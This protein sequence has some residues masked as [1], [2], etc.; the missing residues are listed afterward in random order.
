MA[1][2]QRLLADAGWISLAP[3]LSLGVSG[4]HGMYDCTVPH[5][6]RRTDALAE[7]GRWIDWL[8]EQGAA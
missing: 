5:V 2:L 3:M 4:R 6:P 7:I 8:T 1:T